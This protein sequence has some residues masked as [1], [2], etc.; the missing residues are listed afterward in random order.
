MKVVKIIL[1]NPEGKLLLNHRDKNS[2]FSPNCWS[3]FGGKIEPEETPEQAIVRE[4][5]E[6]TDFDLKEFSLFKKYENETPIRFCFVGK[7]N[8]DISELTLTEGDDMGFFSLEEASSLNLSRMAKRYI[9]DYFF[10]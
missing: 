10:K 2:Q 8:K 6:E 1:L 3:L 9:K 4:I 5:K 7:I